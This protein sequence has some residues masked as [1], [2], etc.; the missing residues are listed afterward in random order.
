MSTY[1]YYEC[2]DHTPALKSDDEFTQHG[3]DEWFRQGI[4]LANSRPV[5][6]DEGTYWHTADA[7]DEH[8]R[9]RLYFRMN[10]LKFLHFHP[11]CRLGIV[12]EYGEQAPIE[13]TGRTA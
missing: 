8:E 10:A 5:P 3:G 2:L 1:W 4:D 12:N 9:S 7:G 6:A 11:T 13:P